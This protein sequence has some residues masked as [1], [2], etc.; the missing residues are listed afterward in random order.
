[1]GYSRK[2]KNQLYL[3]SIPIIVNNIVEHSRNY[4][5]IL[6]AKR[7]ELGLKIE[8]IKEFKNS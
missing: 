1:M 3:F 4:V 2:I 7:K 6:L 5:I 8:L